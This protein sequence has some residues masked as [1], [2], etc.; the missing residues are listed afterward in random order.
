MCMCKMKAF[1]CSFLHF[2]QVPT[3][4]DRGGSSCYSGFIFS[5]RFLLFVSTSQ[6]QVDF[7]KAH[8]A[9]QNFAKLNCLLHAQT[10][11]ILTKPGRRVIKCQPKQQVVLVYLLVIT[12]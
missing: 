8:H 4:R 3:A 1:P 9:V 5:Y 10:I 12:H 11:I 2:L 6:N 7:Y